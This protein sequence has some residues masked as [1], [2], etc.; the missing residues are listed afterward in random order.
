M[1]CQQHQS[2]IQDLGGGGGGGGLGEKNL[3]YFFV[4][5]QKNN[6]KTK[7][8]TNQ[9]EV[10]EELISKVGYFSK[11]FLQ[12]ME[13]CYGVKVTGEC[14]RGAPRGSRRTEVLS[15]SEDFF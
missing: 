6:K 11:R 7:T 1:V 12:E 13:K 3:S 8:K 4:F 14:T 15:S 2:F 9:K 10:W 5:L